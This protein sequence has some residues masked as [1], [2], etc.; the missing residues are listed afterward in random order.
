MSGVEA[1]Y[2]TRS[3]WKSEDGGPGINVDAMA[4][5]LSVPAG[6]HYLVIRGRVVVMIGDGYNGLGV[7]FVSYSHGDA[8]TLLFLDQ[9]NYLLNCFL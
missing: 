4:V 2:Q 7:L 9:L 3:V 5:R 1:A 8:G 6:T